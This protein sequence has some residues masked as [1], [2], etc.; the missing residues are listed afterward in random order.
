MSMPHPTMPDTTMQNTYLN[1]PGDSQVQCTFSGTAIELKIMYIVCIIY[2][3][4]TRVQDTLIQA[5]PEMSV[6]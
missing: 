2:F 1:M 5:D 3:L 6:Y 4:P